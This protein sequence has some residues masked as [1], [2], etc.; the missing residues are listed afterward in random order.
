MLLVGEVQHH[1]IRVPRA[2]ESLSV[3]GGGI[4]S[5]EV[6]VSCAELSGLHCQEGRA[7]WLHTGTAGHHHHESYQAGKN[8]YAG[9]T[10]IQCG[11]CQAVSSLS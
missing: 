6:S 2:A 1:S 3:A 5:A 9:A 4:P 8:G 11:C 10:E 7:G